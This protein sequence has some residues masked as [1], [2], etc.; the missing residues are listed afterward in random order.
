[1]EIEVITDSFMF[2]PKFFKYKFFQVIEH[3]AFKDNSKN[4]YSFFNF[5]MSGFGSF[6][7]NKR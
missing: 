3:S 6:N 4:S 7:K 1:M 2:K 5:L